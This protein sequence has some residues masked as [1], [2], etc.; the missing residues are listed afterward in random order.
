MVK[1]SELETDGKIVFNGFMAT[2]FT[3]GV[4]L[5]LGATFT[6]SLMVA[7]VPLACGAFLAT[8]GGIVDENKD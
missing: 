6:E 8:V 3:I 2:F 7:T 4:A 1:F 5:I